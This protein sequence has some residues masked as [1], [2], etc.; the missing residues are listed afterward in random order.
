MNYTG[1][2]LNLNNS[3]LLNVASVNG[4]EN[5]WEINSDGVLISRISDVNSDNN[6]EVY[7]LSSA[8]VEVQISSSSVL[9]GNEAAIVLPE[10]LQ[11]IISTSTPIKVLITFTSAPPVSGYFIADKDY[12]GFKLKTVGDIPASSTFDWLVIA[13]RRGYEMDQSVAVPATDTV[14]PGPESSGEESTTD[15]STPT[16]IP[17]NSEESTTDTS[18]PPV[19][20]SDTSTPSADQVVVVPDS[21]PS[22]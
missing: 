17:S 22:P 1:G 18:T 8:D 19:I 5:K 2:N 3:S 9:N 21:P 20:P 6:K 4:K 14:I 11:N 10:D 16:V 12:Q 7:G 13:R 15:T